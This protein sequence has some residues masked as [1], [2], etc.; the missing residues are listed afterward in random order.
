[1]ANVLMYTMFII[2]A[3]VLGAPAL[4]GVS[5]Y[6]I[7]MMS[8]LWGA[9]TAQALMTQPRMEGGFM[10]LTGPQI[11]PDEL[12]LFAIVCIILTT[13]FAAL[14]IGAIRTGKAVDGAKLIPI[15]LII[16]LI[17]FFIT[18]IVITTTF[19]AIGGF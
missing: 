13:S 7:Q 11:T 17:I 2:F 10:K 14:I 12:Q 9:E 18:K 8:D 16:A 15:L 3:S 1:M 4:F 6:F 19:G 5:L